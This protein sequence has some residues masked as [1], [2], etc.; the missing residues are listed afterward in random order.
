MIAFY[1][2]HFPNAEMI[3]DKFHV[4]RLLTPAINRRRREITG[5]KRTHP[6]IKLLLRNGHR[7]EYFEKRALKEYGLSKMTS[8]DCRRQLFNSN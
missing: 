2:Q 7:L 5:D 6:I 8:N 3:A 1:I 4:L